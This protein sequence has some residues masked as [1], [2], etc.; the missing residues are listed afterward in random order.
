MHRI[1]RQMTAPWTVLALM[2]VSI[3][4]PTAGV[5]WFMLRAVD[6]ERL[7]VRQRLMDVYGVQAREGAQAFETDMRERFDAA[8]VDLP[9]ASLFREWVVAGVCGACVVIDADGRVVY[10]SGPPM[11]RTDQS[12][13]SDIAMAE[14]RDLEFVRNDP[15]GA[16]ERYA[17]IASNAREP[18]RRAN[19]LVSEARCLAKSGDGDG[20]V[21]VYL[22]V[23]EDKGLR[24]ACS[25][26]G[27]LVAPD[28]LLRALELMD[29]TDD[30][31]HADT[32]ERFCDRVLDYSGPGMPSRQRRF[33]LS[34]LWGIDTKA[35]SADRRDGTVRL[36]EAEEL[37]AEYLDAGI[38]HAE[39]S[40]LM[41]FGI[42]DA[43]HVRRSAPE[44]GAVIA[45]VKGTSL[46]ADAQRCLSA[47]LSDGV[48]AA[49]LSPGQQPASES[50]VA[51]LPVGDLLPDWELV[52]S[53]EGEDPFR[54]A[55]DRRVTAYVWTGVLF[56]AAVAVL[57]ALVVRRVLKDMA[58]ARLKNELIATVTHELKTPLASMRVLVDTL[59]DGRCAGPDQER[60]YLALIARENARLSH[61]IDNFLA[62]SRMERNKRTFDRAP[63]DPAV[64][65]SEAADAVGER[66]ESPR[67][68]F[69]ME[70]AD[71]L[72]CV[73]GDRDALVSVL[74]N[75]LDNAYKYTDRDKDIRLRAYA[76]G[77]MVCFDVTDNGIGL[78]RRAAR[79]VFDRF[80]QVDQTLS[81]RAGGCGLGL[82]IVQ[83]IVSAHG[84]SV[85]VTSTHGEGSV[86][87]VRLPA[88]NGN[89]ETL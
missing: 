73:M 56:I 80:Y 3:V 53:L 32:L 28:A 51:R 61:L 20:A 89:D 31:R 85:D 45:L 41:P 69:E 1:T 7:A 57:A 84:G 44:G 50:V 14:A 16:A 38:S 12:D 25:A 47:E 60:E 5:L 70:V 34:R 8:P 36:R 22:R 64:V 54:V 48:A 35:L 42:P 6:N 30:P 59:M 72:P 39:S 76:S 74:L 83:F 11:D 58:S 13:P 87:T 49:L 2:L 67:C 21:D 81:R 78:T 75:L 66:F 62:F 27:R 40:G 10:P 18:G 79:K 33:L 37:A 86:F 43:Y 88:A 23:G 55:A 52:L 77:G 4:A 29:S 46:V 15:E 19:A 17:E 24:N 68:S 9:A 65:A 71:D 26:E 63:L 82:S